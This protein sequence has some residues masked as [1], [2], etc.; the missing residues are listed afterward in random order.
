MHTLRVTHEK[1]LN[2]EVP[3]P[4]LKE[5]RIGQAIG[6][7]SAGELENPTGVVETNHLQKNAALLSKI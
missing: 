2:G 7:L 1:G 5:L 6:R 4:Q 3:F